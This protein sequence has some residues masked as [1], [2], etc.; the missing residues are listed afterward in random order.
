MVG[1]GLASHR[2]ARTFQGPGIVWV[3]R[4]VGGILGVIGLVLLGI[5]AKEIFYK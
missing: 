5:S 4:G 2:L 3:K 1:Y